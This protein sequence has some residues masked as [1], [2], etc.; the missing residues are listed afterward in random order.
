MAE[1]VKTLFGFIPNDLALFSMLSM[2]SQAEAKKYFIERFRI[3]KWERTVII[4]WNLLDG[5]PQI[6]DAV[7]D[8]YFE[9]KLAYDY[10]KRSQS[11][12]CFMFDEPINEAW[13][14]YGVN[15]TNEAFD[16]ICK[17]TNVDSGETVYEEKVFVGPNESVE[18]TK[19]PYS[20]EQ[21]CYHISWTSNGGVTGENHYYANMPNLKYEKYFYAMK[22]IG[23]VGELEEI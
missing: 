3:K 6:S 12:V 10:I 7:V 18:I 16:G 19:I 17:I 14:V 9:K 11:A 15:D 4:W 21:K 5:W 2:I 20:R 1:Q 23:F 13:S 22:K 8:F